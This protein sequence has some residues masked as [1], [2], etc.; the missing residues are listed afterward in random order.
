M[1]LAG[2]AKAGKTSAAVMTSPGPC[3]VFNTDGK[4]AL[5]P[6]VAL[7]PDNQFA[8]EDITSSAS[9]NAGM[10]WLKAHLNDFETV[11][12]DN[13]TGLAGFIELE[14]RNEIGRDDPRV[15]YPEYSRR[16]MK[17]VNDLLNL[18]RHVIIVG[19]LE[20]GENDTPG[21]F[22]HMLGVAG[23]A[24]THVSMIIQDWVWL[25]VGME[26]GVAKRQFLLAPQGNWNKGARS[27]QNIPRMDA[28]VSKFIE[29]MEKGGVK[30]KVATPAK[31]V[32]V[33]NGKP[34]RA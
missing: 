19:H 6:I 4:G 5:D 32:T 31:P 21:S 26:N 13:I 14:V 29:L 7:D 22:G 24:K 25:H 16:L 33:V 18:P 1:L 27:I 34:V 8:A 20:A 23:K 28:N 2:P 9:F 17:C 11:V 12:L 30:P 3:F 15:I 10:S